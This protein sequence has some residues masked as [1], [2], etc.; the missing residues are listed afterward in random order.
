MAH[1]NQ[2]REF[3][4]TR[5]GVQLLDVYVGPAGLLTGTAR[6]AQ[7]AK[8]RAEGVERKQRLEG[9]SYE[10]ENARRQLEAQI[11]K[12]RSDFELQ[13]RDLVRDMRELRL[14]ERQIGEDR[15]EMGRFR[16]ADPVTSGVNGRR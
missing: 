4:L 16:E 2:I 1:S 6:V 9:K 14:R 13:E 8:E 10:L 7:E 5:H 11:A 15:G 12:M 3:V